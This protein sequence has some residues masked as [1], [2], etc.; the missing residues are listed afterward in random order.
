MTL[1]VDR[2]VGDLLDAVDRLMPAWRTST[3]VAALVA[4]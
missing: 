3:A 4:A 1:D 2:W